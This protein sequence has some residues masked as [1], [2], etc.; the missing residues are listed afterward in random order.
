MTYGIKVPLDE[1]MIWVGTGNPNREH[2]QPFLCDTREEA[3]EQALVWGNKA[4][5][6]PWTE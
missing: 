4:E 1:M 3:Q 5:V 6:H 2:F